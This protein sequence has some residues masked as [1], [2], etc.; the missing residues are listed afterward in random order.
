MSPFCVIVSRVLA[1]L[2]DGA[3]NTAQGPIAARLWLVDST[4]TGGSNENGRS[5]SED[6]LGISARRLIEA[7]I[8]K[9][10]GQASGQAHGRNQHGRYAG[11]TTGRV[12]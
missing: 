1:S 7:A 11:L 5:T 8:G 2:A 3:Q 6:L 12:G 9:Q 10:F 4:R